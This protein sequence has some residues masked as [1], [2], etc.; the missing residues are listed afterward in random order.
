M[1]VKVKLSVIEP[2]VG[3]SFDN[4]I[5]RIV[6]DTV[7]LRD[8]VLLIDGSFESDGLGEVLCD[9]ENGCVRRVVDR[10]KFEADMWSS[11]SGPIN[12][13]PFCPYA[14]FDPEESWFLC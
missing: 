6:G 7:D 9:D 8:T 14:Y 13:G 5:Y 3:S 1:S 2:E 4:N 10:E 12:S 11:E